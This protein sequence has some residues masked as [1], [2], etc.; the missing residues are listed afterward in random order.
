MKT[1]P[2]CG[3]C[4]E[5]LNSGQKNTEAQAFPT[6]CQQL[7]DTPEADACRARGRYSRDH[8]RR[9]GAPRGEDPDLCA[10]CGADIRPSVHVH[11]RL[12]CQEPRI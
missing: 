12:L 3:G 11:L 1:T 2:L 7:D 6:S 4:D 9:C 5:R 10:P 8:G